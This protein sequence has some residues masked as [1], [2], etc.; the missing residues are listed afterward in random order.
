MMKLAGRFIMKLRAL[1]L[2]EADDI[3]MKK[4]GKKCGI[5]TACQRKLLV[6][7]CEHWKGLIVFYDYPEV[8]MDNN[9]AEQSMRNP[10]LGR[11]GY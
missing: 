7:L 5:L 3:E 4:K 11:N 9:P 6:S 8:K 1:A 2:I 10:V